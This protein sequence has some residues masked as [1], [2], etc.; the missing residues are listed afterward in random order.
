MH[1]AALVASTAC[2][3]NQS[4]KLA[5]DGARLPLLAAVA[6]LVHDRTLQ[7]LAEKG[8][9]SASAV[10]DAPRE[11]IPRRGRSLPSISA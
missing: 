1:Q 10:K 9:T 6:D 3:E 7:A 5:A 4:C 2:K 8:G 11:P